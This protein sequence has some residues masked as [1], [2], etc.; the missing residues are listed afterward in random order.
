[1]SKVVTWDA[2]APCPDCGQERIVGY[3]MDNELGEHMHTHYV[4]T[5]WPKN[6]PGV[7]AKSV[8]R[9]CGWHG[10]SVPGWDKDESSDAVN[11]LLEQVSDI[12]A[13]SLCSPTHDRMGETRCDDCNHEGRVASLF[14]QPLLNDTLA[15]VWDEAAEATAEWMATNPGPSGIGSD[16]PRNPYE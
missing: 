6:P 12:V 1:M 14:M 5:F 8:T 13:M 4:C 15:E 2:N 3:R 10:W 11:D 7:H 9:P 16:P